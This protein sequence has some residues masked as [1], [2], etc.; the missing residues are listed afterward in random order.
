MHKRIQETCK[1]NYKVEY[2]SLLCKRHWIE[3]GSGAEWG[4][5]LV[6][7]HNF[8]PPLNFHC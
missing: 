5:K 3:L 1:S 2:R 6:C 7:L 8:Y 4:S